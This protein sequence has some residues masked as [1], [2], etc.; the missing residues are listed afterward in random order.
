MV[1]TIIMISLAVSLW[2]II[3]AV[4]LNLVCISEHSFIFLCVLIVYFVT[5]VV[6]ACYLFGDQVSGDSH[7]MVI[8]YITMLH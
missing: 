5:S 7:V 2:A 1:S 8:P 4:L 3:F 6:T